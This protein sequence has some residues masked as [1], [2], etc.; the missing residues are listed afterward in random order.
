[1]PSALARLGRIAPGIPDLL[2]YRLTDLPYDLTAGLAVA[3]VALPVGVA[4]AQLAG[5]DPVVGLYSSI[6]PLFA[7]ALFGT[8]R[9]LIVG[10]D[11]ATCALIAAA[12]AP[13]AAGDPGLYVAFSA[14]LALLAGLFCIAASFLKLGALADF[15]SKPILVG[16]L[17][18]VSISIALGQAGKL[19]GFEL[20]ARGILPRIY[21]IIAEIGQTHWPTFG[22]AGLAFAVL[23]LAPRLTRR[24]PAA[25]L[26]MVVA[27]A[28]IA[29]LGGAADG[30]ATIGAV[31]AGLPALGLP[32]LPMDRLTDALPQLIASAAGIALISFSSAMLTARSFAAKNRYD[33]DVDREFAA[34]GAANIASALS[35]GFA[36]S[37]AD[38]RTAM[39]DASG[40][41]TRVAGL[42]AAGAVALVLLFLT[43]PLEYVPVA[44]LGA[45]LIMASISLMDVK[46]LRRFWI[47]D[48]RE[49]A[50]SVIATLGVVWVGAIN[51]ILFA[52]LLAL[53]RFVQLAA[54]PR[55]EVLGKVK[56]HA[57]LHSIDRHA[58]ART[59]PGLVLF[60]FN[61]PLV[62][63]NAA[64]FKRQVL[65]AAD[66]AGPELRWVVLDM[67][68]LTQV[69]VTGLDTLS[70]LKAE[71]RRHGVELVAAGRRTEA[72]EWLRERGLLDKVEATRHFPT[73]RQALQAFRTEHPVSQAGTD[74]AAADNGRTPG[75]RA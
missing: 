68:P 18:G 65:A 63:F 52:V 8:S 49:F 28:A 70:E 22:I 26:A 66:R 71:L 43:G 10:P 61:G 5:F 64:Y 27:G 60:R 33:I 9:Q 25:L 56:G 59:T 32:A 50:L 17:N 75:G 74:A 54:R 3:A 53:V 36:I 13:L 19:F 23:L 21:E 44:A 51:A 37:G 15:L 73:L 12:V 16:F 11:A 29:V 72:V 30:I 6:L 55:T 7:Y 2:R 24:L 41:R 48:K 35:Q 47:I 34:L 46:S 39:S 1:M 20:D 4:Y 31:P 57:G 45:V 69:D 38:S 62:F 42:F 58:D 14:L 67:I 40:G